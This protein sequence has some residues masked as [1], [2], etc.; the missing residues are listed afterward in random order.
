VIHIASGN[1]IEVIVAPDT[2]WRRLQFQRREQIGIVGDIVGFAAHPEDV[3]LG[4]LL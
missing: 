4:K 3:I 1:K 2:E